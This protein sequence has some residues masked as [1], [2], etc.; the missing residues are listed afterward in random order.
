MEILLLWHRN[1]MKYILF[2]RNKYYKIFFPIRFDKID[3]TENILPFSY[4]IY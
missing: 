1:E 3:N 4:S 2:W